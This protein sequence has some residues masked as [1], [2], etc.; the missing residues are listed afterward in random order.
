MLLTV[1]ATSGPEWC[2]WWLFRKSVEKASPV[3]IVLRK[4]QASLMP[5]S[6]EPHLTH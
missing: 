3:T 1:N 5:S 4:Y 6:K 2:F